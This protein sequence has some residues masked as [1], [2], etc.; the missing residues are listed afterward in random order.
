MKN[1]KI[2]FYENQKF[3]QWWLWLI[4]FGSFSFSFYTI[5]RSPGLDL[6]QPLNIITNPAFIIVFCAFIAIVALFLLMRLKTTISDTSIMIHLR[7]FTKK[8][9]K[10]SE[11]ERA[12][13]LNYGFIGGWGIRLFTKYGTAYNIKG[14]IGLALE[15]KN[16]KKYLIG[17]Q[18]GDLLKTKI[19]GFIPKEAK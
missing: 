1:S 8:E 3:N 4:L 13:V 12:K 11:I 18:K 17:T 6:D 7:P 19:E 2:V 16:G 14:S 9:F 5:I 10:W 15:L